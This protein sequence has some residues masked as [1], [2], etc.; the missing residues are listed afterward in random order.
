MNVQPLQ[1]SIEYVEVG[2]GNKKS[3]FM[4]LSP[5][6][7]IVYLSYAAC[8][9]YR[10]GVLNFNIL[11]IVGFILDNPSMGGVRDIYFFEFSRNNV[12]TELWIKWSLILFI[13]I[14][15]THSKYRLFYFNQ[16]LYSLD[17]GTSYP[18]AIFIVFSKESNKY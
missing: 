13:V 2:H 16:F 14:C 15:M 3:R 8:L 1:K 12:Y 5:A 9:T 10:D 6:R 17:Y 18:K 11:A 7:T 4:S